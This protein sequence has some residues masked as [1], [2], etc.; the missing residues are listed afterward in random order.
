MALKIAVI[1]IHT[2][3]TSL[4]SNIHRAS[5][6]NIKNRIYSHW[7]N[8]FWQ[9]PSVDVGTNQESNTFYS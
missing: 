6:R 2:Y 5:F 7:A 8:K 1:Y 4:R 3:G 9:S